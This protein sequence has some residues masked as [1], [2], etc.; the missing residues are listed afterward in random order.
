MKAQEKENIARKRVFVSYSQDSDS[1]IEKV[2][3]F[4]QD[5][6]HSGFDAWLDQFENSPREGWTQWM[7]K[8]NREA[9]FVICVGTP[10]YKRRWEGREEAGRG[11]GVI[12]EA[13]T[14][15]RELYESGGNN[16]KYI[17]VHFDQQRSAAIPDTLRDYTSYDVATKEGYKMLLMQLRGQTPASPL[18]IPQLPEDSAALMKSQRELEADSPSNPCDDRGSSMSNAIVLAN[19]SRICKLRDQIDYLIGNNIDIQEPYIGIDPTSILFRGYDKVLGR[20]VGIKV[21][22]IYRDNGEVIAAT[23][24]DKMRSVAQL[25]HSNIVAVHGG[26]LLDNVPLLIL[27]YINGITLDKVIIKTGKQPLRRI[28]KFIEEIGGALAYAHRRNFAHHYLRPDN[29]LVNS[30]GSPVITPFRSIG[31][32]QDPPPSLLEND[33]RE[34]WRW[35]LAKYESPEQIGFVSASNG[36]RP[37][38]SDQYALGLIAFDMLIGRPALGATSLVEFDE[39][40]RAF[41]S[42]PPHPEEFGGACPDPLWRVLARMLQL[43]PGD[44]YP[45]TGEL[46]AEIRRIE[47]VALGIHETEITRVAQ[48]SYGRCRI[49]KEFFADFYEALFEHLPGV[50]SMFDLEHIERQHWLLREGLELLLYYPAES[51]RGANILSHTASRHRERFLGAEMYDSFVDA[52]L[53]T[54]KK[55]DELCRTQH[56]WLQ[57]IEAWKQAIELGIQFMKE[58]GAEE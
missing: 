18:P 44:R 13:A 27:E 48:E 15:D 45:N 6:R 28:L 43:R 5:L 8:Q 31:K 7:R 23:F 30:E 42:R 14:S 9:K 12:R 20:D 29:I 35:R 49:S 52:L 1:H 26:L 57:I 46:L 16:Q 50:R 38:L 2:T 39:Q 47:P 33:E 58:N 51:F 4:A 54:V 40:K 53:E 37:D 34:N 10:T 25:K 41:C 22:N 24:Y 17:P 56:G 11:L 21:P 3:K 19:E 36:Y 32:E 55:H